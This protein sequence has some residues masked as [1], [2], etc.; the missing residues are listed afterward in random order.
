MLSAGCQ[1]HFLNPASGAQGWLASTCHFKL[2]LPN[3][4]MLRRGNNFWR[5][6]YPLPAQSRATSSRLLRDMSCWTCS[7]SK[8]CLTT[9][10]SKKFFLTLKW[11]F[12]HFVSSYVL[13]LGVTE[14][15]LAPSSLFHRFRYLHTLI[16]SPFFSPG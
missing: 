3:H 16:R 12:L 14:K 15:S 2:C 6:Y 1:R 13:P 7:V 8:W 10:H 4:R 9:I 5:S 11:K